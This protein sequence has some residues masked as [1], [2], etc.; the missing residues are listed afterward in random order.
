MTN[1]DNLSATFIYH[2]KILFDILDENHSGF[3]RLSDIEGHWEGNHCMIPSDV[4]IQCLR[5]VALPSGR[6]SFDTFTVGLQRALTLWKSSRTDPNV[7]THLNENWEP[8][9][10]SRPPH[11]SMSIANDMNH[12]DSLTRHRDAHKSSAVWNGRVKSDDAACNIGSLTSRENTDG[13]KQCHHQR[14]LAGQDGKYSH[15][16]KNKGNKIII[17]SRDTSSACWTNCH[18]M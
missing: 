10:D 18:L 8:S 12:I 15:I 2:M 9:P 11:E 5:N 6:L 3:V 14:T 7:I 1:S 13:L 17:I 4:V 16:Q